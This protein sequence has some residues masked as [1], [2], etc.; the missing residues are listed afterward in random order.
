MQPELKA[1]LGALTI[2]FQQEECIKVD[3]K[4]SDFGRR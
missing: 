4:P 2:V 3:V 1:H